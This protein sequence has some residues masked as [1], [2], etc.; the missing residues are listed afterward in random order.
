[1]GLNWGEIAA[2]TA[3]LASIGGLVLY[4]I[5]GELRGDVTRLDGRINTHER[6][7]EEFR[8][9]IDSSLDSIDKKQDHMDSKLD[10]LIE[11]R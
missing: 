4:V 2:V 8:K 7:C 5:R 11:A 6:G 9:R 1:M 10:R 3:I